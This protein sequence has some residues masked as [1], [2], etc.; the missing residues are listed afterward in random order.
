MLGDR[1]VGVFDEVRPH[2]PN[3]VAERAR[4]AA[5]EAGADALLS[6]G[7]GIHHRHREDHRADHRPADRRGPDDVRRARR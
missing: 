7:G 6:I 4:A 5:A 2:V 3:E 1:V